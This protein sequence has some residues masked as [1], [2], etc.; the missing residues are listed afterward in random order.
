MSRIRTEIR[1]DRPIEEVFAYVTTP[2]SWLDW[3]PSSVRITGDTDH[4]LLVGESVSEDFVVAG[5]PGSVTWTVIDRDLPKRWVISG[6]VHGA[7]GGK[8]AY[9]FASDGNVTLFVREFTYQMENWALSLLDWLLVRRRIDK[10]S[11]EALRR[12]KS[13][14][15]KKV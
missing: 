10:E 11:T 3:H 13:A 9:S 1:I 12:L 14:M 8:I 2:E 4:S 15:E 5:Q 6:H 7:G